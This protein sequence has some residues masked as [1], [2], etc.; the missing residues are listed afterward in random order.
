[1]NY[2]KCYKNYGDNQIMNYKRYFSGILGWI[3]GIGIF[4]FIVK[5]PETMLGVMFMILGY[6]VLSGD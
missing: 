5:S 3:T 6:Y 1:M 2:P 4:I